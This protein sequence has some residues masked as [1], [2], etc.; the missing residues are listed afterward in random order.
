MRPG[1]EERI[2]GG[3]G[4]LDFD[5]EVGSTPDLSR[6][7]ED[8]GTGLNVLGIGNGTANASLGFHQHLMPMFMECGDHAWHATHSGFVIFD[9]FRNADDQLCD[10]RSYCGMFGSGF[11][12]GSEATLPSCFGPRPRRMR[13]SAVIFPSGASFFIALKLLHGGDGIGIPR[14][15][16]LT[17]E[18]AF[19]GE[20]LFE[21]L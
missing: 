5:N 19:V 10:L 13:A 6:G 2:F 4:F 15:V 11:W 20:G 18:I 8:S 12:L 9:F 17:L 7:W 3:L 14:A 21:F 16:Y 1:A